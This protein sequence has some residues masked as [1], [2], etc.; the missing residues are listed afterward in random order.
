MK[1]S[2]DELIS[3]LSGV[4][5]EWGTVE[6][7]FRANHVIYALQK[8]ILEIEG[9]EK[10]EWIKFD[11]NNEKS[12]PNHYDSV[13]IA[14]WNEVDKKFNEIPAIFFEDRFKYYASFNDIPSSKTI[15]WR[16]FPMLPKEISKTI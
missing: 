14:W 7:V 4:G 2:K 8:N 12:F 13:I 5:T 6:E 15:Y 9:Y 1:L 16:L 11:C 10:N 3:L